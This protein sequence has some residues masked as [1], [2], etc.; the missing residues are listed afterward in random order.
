MMGRIELKPCPFCNG[1]VEYHE[2]EMGGS[3]VEHKIKYKNGQK[4]DCILTD[5][6][7]AFSA[8]AGMTWNTRQALTAEFRKVVEPI[9]GYCVH[10]RACLCS[11]AQCGEPTDEEGYGG[12]KTLYGY[13]SNEKWYGRNQKPPCSC[14]LD[15][16]ITYLNQLT[17]QAKEQGG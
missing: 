11:Q 16:W 3:W 7:V 2:D 9:L 4:N 6:Q 10:D 8:K 13:G 5:S 12:Y 14:G 17:N 1:E 15:E